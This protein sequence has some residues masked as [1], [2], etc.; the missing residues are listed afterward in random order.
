MP[1]DDLR[2]L[3]Q[4]RQFITHFQ[5]IFDAAEQGI[6][7]HEALARGATLE[8]WNL[9]L[10]FFASAEQHGCVVE[11][12]ML[13]LELAFSRFRAS[14]ARGKLFVNVM[15]ATL[16]ATR[17]L[18]ANIKSWLARDRWHASDVV[19]EITEH[20]PP[21][22][23][24][25]ISRAVEPLRS[26]GCQIAID[27]LGAGTSGLK[28]WS[29]LRPDY[30]KID[31]YFIDRIESD[32][33][34]AELMRSLLDIAHVMGSRVIA[35]A[36]ER[37]GQYQLLRS[38]GVDYL[39]GYLLGRP[40]PKPCAEN[41]PATAE[42]TEAPSP[43]PSCAEGLLIPRPGVAPDAR[44]EEVLALFQENRDW[45]CIVVVDGEEPVGIVR[46]DKLLTLLSKPLHPE[47]YNRK[48]VSRV[49]EEQPLVVDARARLDQVSR[50]V[51]NTA[52]PRVNE[53]FIIA[54]HGNY[55]GIGHTI[56]LLRQITALQ[57][58]AAKQCNPL[59]LLPGN[60]EI[61]EEL[62]RLLALRSPFVVC[63]GDLDYFKP[64][65]DEYGYRQG[66]QVLL[67]VADLFRHAASHGSDFVGHIGGDDFILMLR[68]LDWHARLQD[69]FERFSASIPNFY[70]EA[71][72]SRG[73]F[74]S[75][76]RDG[77]EREFP[78]LTLSIGAVLVDPERMKTQDE[79]LS[80][81]RR[82]KSSA[83]AQRG[84]SLAYDRDGNVQ[85]LSTGDG[86][87]R[88]LADSRTVRRRAL[89]MAREPGSVPSEALRLSRA[90]K[91]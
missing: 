60:R 2:R 3:M 41:L 29:E 86:P 5:P 49:M 10:S 17:E 51:T 48:P 40:E 24:A 67:H 46:R 90:E 63:H 22:D 27:D 87:T 52:Q 88:P 89:R 57:L 26:L 70:S 74:T 15:P 8:P 42:R 81:L 47:I 50:L 66:D 72:R 35:E 37:P 73:G 12:D 39:Q 38:M 71:H 80:C 43:A 14:G 45:D 75:L 32:P 25:A 83:K 55:L 84:N 9:P 91:K 23:P 59:T 18:T 28:I 30:V 85:L 13:L 44:V 64:F 1:L 11:L 7:G 78:L 77:R 16:L 19:L 33:V 34:A 56:D 20:G 76:D 61:G 68:N 58:E 31:R 6:F 53:D 62:F 21:R 36:I 82:V 69:L 79:V 54:R 65:N 4:R